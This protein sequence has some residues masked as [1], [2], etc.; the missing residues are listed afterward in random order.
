MGHLSIPAS[1]ARLLVVTFDGLGK[2]RVD[3]VAH[4]RLVNAHSKGNCCTYHLGRRLSSSSLTLWKSLLATLR[5]SDLDEET[6]RT[7]N[8][9]CNGA[10][11]AQTSNNLPSSQRSHSRHGTNPNSSLCTAA[12]Q[13]LFLKPCSA[14]VHSCWSSMPRYSATAF[15]SQN[16]H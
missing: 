8:L 3:N 16:S 15:H 13:E 4:V 14:Q 9:S 5:T 7:L 10:E 6:W 12:C 1:S 2:G 11:Q